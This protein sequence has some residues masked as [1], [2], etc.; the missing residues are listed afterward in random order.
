M[1]TKR[2]RP[3]NDEYLRIVSGLTDGIITVIIGIT[4]TVFNMAEIHILHRKGKKRSIPKNILSLAWADIL[5]GFVYIAYGVSKIMLYYNSNSLIISSVGSEIRL[6]V[7]FT[8]IV[9]LFHL[10]VIT[11]E[12]F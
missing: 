7:S 2:H 6:S 8:T 11:A 5:V 1:L 10:L 4:V 12:R 3:V 9:S